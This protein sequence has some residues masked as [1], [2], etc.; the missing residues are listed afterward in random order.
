MPN[1]CCYENAVKKPSGKYPMSKLD[2]LLAMYT[3]G[4]AALSMQRESPTIRIEDSQPPGPISAKS[5]IAAK[6]AI[7]TR[8]NGR[9]KDCSR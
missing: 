6:T 3:V 7:N 4:G 8:C 9:T 1:Q 2:S 5:V